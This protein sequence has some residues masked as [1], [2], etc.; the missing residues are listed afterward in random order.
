MKPVVW[1]A[2]LIAGALNIGLYF[3]NYHRPVANG[4]LAPLGQSL[5]YIV[6]Y[7]GS[8]FVRHS[9]GAIAMLAGVIGILCAVFFLVGTLRHRDAGS[10]LLTALSLLMLFTLA[11]AAITS[12][13]RLHLGIEQATASRYQ[14]FALLFWCCLGLTLLSRIAAER[15][16]VH[17]FA[18]V[19]LIAMLGFATQVR[20]PLIDAQWR[21]LRLK[22]ISLALLTG[23]Q[24]DE[25]LAEA[26]PDPQVVLRSAEYM[27]QHRLSIFAEPDAA[28]LDKPFADAFHR[29]PAAACF[30]ALTSEELLP[31]E[32]GQAMR[33][34]G[35]AW[36]LSRQEP[37]KDILVVTGGKISGFGIVTVYPLALAHEHD[38][39]NASHFEWVA[40]STGSSARI[41]ELY[42][43]SGQDKKSACPFASV[44]P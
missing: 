1:R 33:L 25:L 2:L 26:F 17:M 41:S 22:K 4:G 38:S 32:N 29:I 6:V 5:L 36:D 11:T 3:Y 35:Y 19:L 44:S 34:E 27:R 7:F 14:T 9:D 37:A 10:P 12:T 24:D 18:A 15:R 20:L 43:L 13:G 30:G 21:Q 40:Y 23:V 42:V 31:T 28:L 16:P 39:A 8:T